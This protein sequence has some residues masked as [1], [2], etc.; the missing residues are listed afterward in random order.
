MNRTHLVWKRAVVLPGTALLLVAGTTGCATRADLE[1]LRRNQQQAR[2]VIADQTVAMEEMR[3]RIEMLQSSLQDGAAGPGA[4]S[5]VDAQW[6][7]TIEERLAAV[8]RNAGA[9]AELMPLDR[10][11]PV[12]RMAPAPAG[13]MPGGMPAA[14]A[15]TAPPAAPAPVAVAPVP[16]G[17]RGDIATDVAAEEAALAGQKVSAEYS[18]AMALLRSG[19]CK[20]AVP[21]LRTFIRK[22][23][24]SPYADNAQYWIGRCFYQQKDYNR[25]I[26][27]LYDV[28]L[29]FPQSERVPGA[30][31][32]LADAFADS[33][34]DIDARL[35]LKKLLS[36]HPQA[37]EVAAAR[38]RLQALGE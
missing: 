29:K 4:G 2:R 36:D 9:P 30:L 15:P 16:A 1:Q 18:D 33:G 25:A 10:N 3:R 8:E 31:L 19:N 5:R 7:R 22:D 14:N 6:R 20:D 38:K 28:L 24:K 35:T 34:D 17:E 13:E 23:I 12:D 37:E 11:A 27:E 26:M 21:R 32:V